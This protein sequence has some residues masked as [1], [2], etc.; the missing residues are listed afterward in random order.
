MTRLFASRITPEFA[1]GD[2]WAYSNT[3]YLLLGDIVERV[4]GQTYWEFLR[5]RVFAPAGMQATRSSAPR[6]VIPHRASG[7]GWSGGAF[8]NRPALS[9][10]AYSAGAIASTITDMTKWAI[11]LDS[12]TLVGKTIR[13]RVW[14]PLTVTRGP[15]PPFSYG[16]GW[17]VDQERGHRAVLHSGGTP[18][19]SSA[20]RHYPDDRLTVIVL[21]NHG[22]R[23]LDH[24][25]LEIAGMVFPEVARREGTDPDPALSARL[26][27]VLRSVTAGKANP[28]DFTP[29]MQAFLSTATARGLGEWIASHGTLTSLRYGQ[30]EQIGA[31]RVLRYRAAVGE[32]E[33]WFSFSLTAAN[34]IA[35]IYWW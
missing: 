35:Q 32:A 26:A 30:A 3:G 10:N 13:D 19:F 11:A 16:F 12:G 29:A 23:V 20:I 31:R 33:L 15:V 1:P 14:T 21:A 24:V 25:P 22:D 28:R 18:G 5:A 7:Y 2:T 6:S 17:V 34:E 27:D 8:E 9:E 4:S